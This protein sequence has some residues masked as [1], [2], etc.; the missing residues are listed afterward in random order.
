MHLIGGIG[1]D[2]SIDMRMPTYQLVAQLVNH[3]LHLKEILLGGYFGIEDDVQH[4]VAQFLAHI[5]VVLFD[6]GI[7]E[8]EGLLH[9]EVAQSVESLLTIPRT[10]FTQFV[11]DFEQMPERGKGFGVFVVFVHLLCLTGGLRPRL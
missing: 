7:G 5:L 10:F 8:L 11:H 2:F 6:D 3:I 1:L 4:Q 9:G